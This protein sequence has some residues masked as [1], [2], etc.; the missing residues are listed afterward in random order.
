MELISII[1]PI[2]A[3]FVGWYVGKYPLKSGDKL[4]EDLKE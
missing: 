2:L 4:K 3:F 1:L